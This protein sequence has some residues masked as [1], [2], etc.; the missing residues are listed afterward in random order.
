[1]NLGFSV[2]KQYFSGIS[3]LVVGDVYK[4]QLIASKE[5]LPNVDDS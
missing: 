3:S 4:P 2:V 5:E 1:M